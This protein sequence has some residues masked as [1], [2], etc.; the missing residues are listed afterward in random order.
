MDPSTNLPPKVDTTSATE[1]E[2][3]KSA[4][5]KEKKRNYWQPIIAKYA[6]DFDHLPVPPRNFVQDI[7]KAKRTQNKEKRARLK[8]DLRALKRANKKKQKL[9]PLPDRNK[10]MRWVL[11]PMTWTP[12][13]PKPGVPT[14]T[15][16][17][18]AGKDW[19]PK[20]PNSYITKEEEAAIR[21]RMAEQHDGPDA[22][23]HR[24][25]FEEASRKGLEHEPV[26]MRPEVLLCRYCWEENLEDVF[27]Y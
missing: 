8:I 19:W 9:L 23:T 16:T 10:C 14:I 21:E 6:E 15:V 25:A 5:K 11:M 3:P 22:E 12:P 24:A 26:G 2:R 1:Q 4:T 7:R 17:D 27:V 18:P 13:E 20:D